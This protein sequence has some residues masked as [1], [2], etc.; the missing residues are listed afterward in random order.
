MGINIY[1]L[2]NFFKQ[3][4]LQKNKLSKVLLTKFGRLTTSTNPVLSTKKRLRNSFKTL[5]VTSDPVMNSL[6]KL[7]MRS[8]PLST[9]TTQEPLKRTRWLS[10]S[11]NFLVETEHEKEAGSPCNIRQLIK[12]DHPQRWCVRSPNEVSTSL[13]LVFN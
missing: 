12:K 1:F 3:W 10:S 9:R 4:Q 5:L 7:S 13:F 11:S 2:T 8:S 6:M